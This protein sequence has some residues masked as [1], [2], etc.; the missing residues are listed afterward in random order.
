MHVVIGVGVLGLMTFA[1]TIFVIHPGFWDAI[2]GTAE[3]STA[4]E[5]SSVNKVGD[6]ESDM[7][8]EGTARTIGA[9]THIHARSCRLLI[10]L[11]ASSSRVH[12]ASQHVKR[13]VLR[14]RAAHHP[15]RRRA[16]RLS[17]TMTQSRWTPAASPSL[18][19][20]S[21]CPALTLATLGA[22][23]RRQRSM[24]ASRVRTGAMISVSYLCH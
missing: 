8:P 5:D 3:D 14:L 16:C 17:T 2:G 23:E 4:S 11:D 10:R 7:C 15:P 6:P 21:T 22:S 18:A 19:R 1:L 20:T 24:D 12:V 9:L 13:Q